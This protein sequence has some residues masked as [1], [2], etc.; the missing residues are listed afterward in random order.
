[1]DRGACRTTARGVAKNQLIG[2]KWSAL[3]PML[4]NKRS[5]LKEK[6]G[7]TTRD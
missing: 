7:A 5:L 2:L 6:P 3:E 4:R 1:M